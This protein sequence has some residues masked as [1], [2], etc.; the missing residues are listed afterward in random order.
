ALLN[1]EDTLILPTVT[2]IHIGV[3]PALVGSDGVM[4]LDKTA[5]LTLYQAAKI[6]CDSGAQLRTF[7]HTNYE[8]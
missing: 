4:F 8:G 2:L 5:H 3:I 6:A 7:E 1:V